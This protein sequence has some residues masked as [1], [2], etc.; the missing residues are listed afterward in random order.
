MHLRD[1][2]GKN[3][4][5]NQKVIDSYFKSVPMQR[6]YRNG[7]WRSRENLLNFIQVKDLLTK[8]RWS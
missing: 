8:L 1:M 6:G 4:E 7:W 3:G 5:D 2:K